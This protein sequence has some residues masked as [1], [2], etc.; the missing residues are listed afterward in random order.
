MARPSDGDV[1][2][3]TQI[4]LDRYKGPQDVG[5]NHTPPDVLVD[6]FL[7]PV[8]NPDVFRDKIILE[9]GAGCSQYIPVFLDNGCKRYYANDLVPARLEVSRVDD[10]RYIELLGDFRNITIPETP[11]IIFANLT[12]MF[13]QPML[14]E[15]VQHIAGSLD[16][17]GLF[18]SYD[19]N[20]ICP[21]SIY[22]RFADRGANPARIFNPF[23]YARTFRRH[24]FEVERL[25]PLTARYPWTVGNWLA[26]TSFWLRARKQ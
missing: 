18:F 10:P 23:R 14:D 22:R 21:L 11:D 8:A 12:M 25:V 7:K 3:H 16:S 24:G 4:I 1:D 13:L 2:A 9:L 26:G 6:T 19:P 5:V 15:F 20:Y 17:G